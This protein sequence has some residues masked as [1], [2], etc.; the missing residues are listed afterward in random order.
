MPGS[1]RF[2]VL[3]AALC[4]FASAPLA[5]GQSDTEA[6]VIVTQ[7]STTR[8]SFFVLDGQSGERLS[9]G[10]MGL[11]GRPPAGVYVKDD[12]GVMVWLQ[13]DG[14]LLRH[15]PASYRALGELIPEGEGGAFQGREVVE[16]D[17]V[18][19]VGG[20]L[21]HR[22]AMFD[23]RTGASLG[24]L[25]PPGTAGVRECYGLAVRDDDVLVPSAM[26]GS[27]T[28]FDR[29]TGESLGVLIP[30]GTAGLAG[31]YDVLEATSGELYVSDT[32][33]GNILRFDADGQLDLVFATGM[34]GVRGLGWHPSG[35]LLACA[36]EGPDGSGVYRF[37]VA[38]GDG[39]LWAPAVGPM[40]V[41]I[42]TIESGASDAVVDVRAL[43][44]GSV[45]ADGAVI[46]DQ[47][48]DAGVLFSGTRPSGDPIDLVI[49]GP[50]ED[51]GLFH[52]PE[53]PMATHVFTFVRPGTDEPAFATRFQTAPLF[54]ELGE[55]VTL[56]GLD[57]DG[58]EVASAVFEPT[59]D[60]FDS[61]IAIEADQSTSFARVEVRT[62]GNPG[63]G[64][65]QGARNDAMRF[66]LLPPC[67]ADYDG[68]GA[69]TIF[70]FLLF[71]NDFGAGSPAADFDGDGALTIFDFL[72]F[73]NAFDQGCP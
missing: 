28:R 6:R 61:I 22:I 51:R 59:R 57:A 48:R 56:V 34:P 41:A 50:V 17:G 62:D 15:D 33:S 4:L 71:Q 26:N 63:I 53:V 1:R 3:A 72:A 25:F 19:Y 40:F 14:P 2:P 5:Y 66:R 39:G 7:A 16:R 58:R 29:T 21:S 18:I 43:P 20:G 69:L 13:G 47:Y 46:T 27:V 73:Q 32:N 68:D 36:W 70:D 65:L 54:E 60:V 8:A 24:N 35:D 49:V 64:F 45:P 44:D 38:T 9:G 55:R 10:P 37:D 23:A 12:G 52:R 31:V 11:G 67:P 42:Q 30:A